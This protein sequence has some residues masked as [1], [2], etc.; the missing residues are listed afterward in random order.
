[1]N[2]IW[3]K[4][5]DEDLTRLTLDFSYPS[6]SPF[7]FYHAPSRHRAL[8]ILYTLPV[9]DIFLRATASS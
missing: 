5:W 7:N 1:M 2:T 8:Q 3:E 6:F 4:N 9:G